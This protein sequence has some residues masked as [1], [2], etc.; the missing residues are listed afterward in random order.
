[1]CSIEGSLVGAVCS[2][3]SSTLLGELYDSGVKTEIR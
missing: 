1:M 3:L 2:V